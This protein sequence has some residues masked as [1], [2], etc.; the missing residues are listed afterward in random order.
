MSS[1]QN[2]F[3]KFQCPPPPMPSI[4]SNKNSIYNIGPIFRFHLSRLIN[5][6][7]G[8]KKVR[9]KELLLKLFIHQSLN[10]GLVF[11]IVL[12]LEASHFDCLASPQFLLCFL[13]LRHKHVPKCSKSQLIVCLTL[14]DKNNAQLIGGKLSVGGWVSVIT[15]CTQDARQVCVP[16]KETESVTPRWGAA[17]HNLSA[18]QSGTKIQVL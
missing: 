6:H 9:T 18:E 16:G 17:R 3:N 14:K 1:A 8:K 11:L 10:E 5:F 7:I 4:S 2:K 12:C 13:H 15:L